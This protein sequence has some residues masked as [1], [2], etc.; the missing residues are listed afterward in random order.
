MKKRSVAALGIIAASLAMGAVP[1]T[2]PTNS[3]Q[4]TTQSQKQNEAVERQIMPYRRG[5][6]TPLN[7]AGL[8]YTGYENYGR[9]PKEYG[10]HLQATGKQKWVKAKR[11]K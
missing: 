10:Q 6:V 9:S 3:N 4:G 11:K 5:P 2:V 8:D 1:Q 7:P